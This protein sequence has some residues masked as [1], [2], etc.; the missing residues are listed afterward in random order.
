M[1]EPPTSYGCI[2]HIPSGIPLLISNIAIEHGPVE[3]V[4]LPINS[5]VI[6][7]M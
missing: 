2:I 1:V 5:I 3:I 6:F 4:D 7:D